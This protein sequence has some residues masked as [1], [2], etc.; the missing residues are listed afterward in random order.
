V[1]PPRAGRPRHG[2]RALRQG[3]SLLSYLG[4]ALSGAVLVLLAAIAVLT[5]V[6]PAVVGGT[7]LTVLTNSMAPHLPP[8]TLIVIR[9]TPIAD[10]RVGDVLTYQ[11]ASGSPAVISHRVVS[12]SQGTNGRTT[13]IT[14][15]DNN[16]AAD[17][18]P[19]TEVQ[20]KGTLWYSMPYLGWAA[21]ALGGDA[22]AMLAP[23]AAGLL[24]AYAAYS[25]ISTAIG[26][27]RKASTASRRATK[28]NAR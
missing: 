4:T 10:I 23:L 15:G 25:V 11:I 9:P 12:E 5:I 24:F 28:G 7:A 19:V 26:R 18:K 6:A 20:V 1:R 2:R 8:G 21:N 16:D 22:R 14:K 17:P 13:F 27:R 3:K